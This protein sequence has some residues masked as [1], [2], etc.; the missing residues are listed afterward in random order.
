MALCIAETSGFLDSASSTDASSVVATS[1]ISV[2]SGVSI[3]AATS[4][5]MSGTGVAVAT[6]STIGSGISNCELSSVSRSFLSTLNRGF[7]VGSSVLDPSLICFVSEVGALV[8]FDASF[9]S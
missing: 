4:F 1:A 6:D 3:S 7:L 2:S 8:S 5:L 9:S